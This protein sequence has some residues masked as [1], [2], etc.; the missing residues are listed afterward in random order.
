MAVYQEQ[1]DI[2]RNYQHHVI[3]SQVVVHHARIVQ[4]GELTRNL[5]N[6]L[7]RR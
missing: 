7:L 2:N 1:L 4:E 5:R 3:Q 6:H